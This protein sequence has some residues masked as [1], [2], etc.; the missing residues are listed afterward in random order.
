MRRPARV[1][2]GWTLPDATV[3]VAALAAV[4]LGLILVG[5]LHLVGPT[6]LLEGLR[7]AGLPLHQ[8]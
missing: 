7:A 2:G 1:R 5:A 4:L 3:P 6:G 8:T